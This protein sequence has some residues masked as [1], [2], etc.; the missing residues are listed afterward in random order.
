MANLAPLVKGEDPCAL[1]VN[2]EDAMRLGLEDGGSARITSKAAS[3]VAP[4]RVTDEMTPGVVSLPHG[5]GHDQPGMRLKVAQA[6]AGVSINRLIPD[7]E[8]EPLSGDA[9]LNAIPVTVARA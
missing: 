6:H 3:L 5:W 1:L 7:T 2:T 4:V 8:I 9:I